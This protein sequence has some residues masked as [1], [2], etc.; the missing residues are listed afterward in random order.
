VPRSTSE[1]GRDVRLVG[2]QRNARLQ[3]DHTVRPPLDRNIALQP[4]D[5]AKGRLTE[6]KA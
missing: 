3:D 5:L 4:F 6:L 1:R 2:L